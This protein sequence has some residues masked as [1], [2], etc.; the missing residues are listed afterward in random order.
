M[1]HFADGRASLVFGTHSHIPTADAQIM[2]GGTAC[3]TDLGMCGDYNSVIGM[4]KE[5][6]IARFTRKMPTDRLAP[7]DGEATVCGCVV[8]TDDLTGLVRKIQPVRLGGR[9]LQG[10]PEF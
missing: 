10:M 1:A 5:A 8:E 3:Q 9:L 2:P 7:A 4:R 6:A